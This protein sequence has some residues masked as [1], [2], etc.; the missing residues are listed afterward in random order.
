MMQQI[1]DRCR[2]LASV[3][4]HKKHLAFESILADCQDS[5]RSQRS[6]ETQPV[7]FYHDMVSNLAR[8]LN[9]SQ[10][11]TEV[12]IIDFAKAFAKVPLQ[13]RLLRD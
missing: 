13:T 7:M 6:C 11:K 3:A 2:S 5:F 8:A 1:I 4:K 9:R 10:E 12:M